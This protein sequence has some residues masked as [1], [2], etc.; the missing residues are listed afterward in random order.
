MPSVQNIIVFQITETYQLCQLAHCQYIILLCINN[1][2]GGIG[3]LVTSVGI[4]EIN[5]SKLQ[6]RSHLD[7]NIGSG[8]EG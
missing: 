8:R 1:L 2:S 5:H 4:I 6:T 3:P 7:N